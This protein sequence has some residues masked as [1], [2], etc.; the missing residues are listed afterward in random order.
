MD[1]QAGPEIS[2]AATKTY[3]TQLT[4]LALLS[5]A[6]NPLPQYVEN[7]SA[8]PDQL[9]EIFTFEDHVAQ[10]VERYRYMSHCVMIGRGY[11]YASA[12]EFALKVKELTYTI[13]EPYSSADSCMA[14]SLW[15]IRVSR[16]SS[17]PQRQDER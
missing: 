1:L 6:L 2:L 9:Q 5:T 3:S 11:N 4:T 17:L 14:P 8:F 10:L 15:W 7:L 13:A 12:F 16:S